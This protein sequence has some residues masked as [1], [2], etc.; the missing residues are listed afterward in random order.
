MYV[1]V[2]TYVSDILLIHCHF[3]MQS[4]SVMTSHAYML[5]H[6]LQMSIGVSL[7]GFYLLFHFTTIVRVI[8]HMLLLP[9]TI[10][11]GKGC[12]V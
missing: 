2:L 6:T 12:G 3:K 11:V 9:H 5:L 10:C 7:L 4:K 1:L 8:T